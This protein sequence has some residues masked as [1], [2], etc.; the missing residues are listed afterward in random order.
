MWLEIF[1]GWKPENNSNSSSFWTR[2]CIQYVN[3]AQFLIRSDW[4]LLHHILQLSHENV[5][6]YFSFFIPLFELQC[7][8]QLSLAQSLSWIWQSLFHF[9]ILPSF[10]LLQQVL[11][12]NHIKTRVCHQVVLHAKQPRV[13]RWHTWANSNNK[14]L[15]LIQEPL[16]RI[17]CFAI[18][19]ICQSLEYDFFVDHN[20]LEETLGGWDPNKEFYA[21][22][23]DVVMGLIGSLYLQY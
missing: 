18:Q 6:H 11:P 22:G 19:A 21:Q 8:T 3:E 20:A 16:H 14:G 15:D 23:S 1:Q 2:T 12:K 17:H 4:P 10:L 9:R 13:G 5:V 7:H